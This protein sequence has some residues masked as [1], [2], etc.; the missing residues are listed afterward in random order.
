M[1]IKVARLKCRI[2]EVPISYSGRDYT[3]GKKIG[4]KDGVSPPSSTSSASS[5]SADPAD[6]TAGREPSWQSLGSR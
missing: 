1:T 4:W 6:R 2:Y 3:E 5:F